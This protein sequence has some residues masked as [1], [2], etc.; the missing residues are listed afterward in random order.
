MDILNINKYIR[1]CVEDNNVFFQEYRNDKWN[2]TAIPTFYFSNDYDNHYNKDY[3][4]KDILNDIEDFF[5]CVAP[6]VNKIE[7]NQDDIDD[8][9]KEIYGRNCPENINS[10][11][12]AIISCNV[13]LSE[14]GIEY[15]AFNDGFYNFGL[16]PSPNN[17]LA[18]KDLKQALNMLIGTYSKPMGKTVKKYLHGDYY[19]SYKIA[20][21]HFLYGM[22]AENSIKVM[23]E[24]M[25]FSQYLMNKLEFV[26]LPINDDGYF[27]LPQWVLD[28]SEDYKVQWMCDDFELF[29]D[30]ISLSIHNENDLKNVDYNTKNIFLIHNRIIDALNYS[31]VIDNM[32]LKE[33]VSPIDVNQIGMIENI[34][35]KTLDSAFDLACAGREMNICV[36][37][38]LYY[39]RLLS[40][41]SVFLQGFVQNDDLNNNYILAEIDVKTQKIIECRK[42]N[43]HDVSSLELSI[44][45]KAVNKMFYDEKSLIIAS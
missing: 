1:L 38:E 2:I 42:C 23:N 16:I 28:S 20:L 11:A 40:G 9:L 25:M 31:F 27:I 33:N 44:V 29:L 3:V 43:N 18:S 26:E 34:S 39:K 7:V 36:G 35:F 12:R 30:C 8:Y 22:S 17:V 45:E 4:H 24:G 6:W 37:S 21:L 5:S 32:D 10:L 15:R 19:A 41:S 14:L 13:I